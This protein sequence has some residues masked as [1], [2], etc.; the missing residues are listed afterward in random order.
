MAEGRP[1]L[2]DEGQQRVL[3]GCMGAKQL[4]L[5]Q[6][7]SPAEAAIGSADATVRVFQH[8]VFMLGR[9]PNR[10]KL[11]WQRRAAINQALTLYEEDQL[12]AAIEGMAADAL[13]DCTS[14]RI[15]DAMREI[16]WLL[17]KGARIER[18]AEAGDRL[19]L[20]AAAAARQPAQPEPARE[21]VDPAVTASAREAL[22]QMAAAR[23]GAPR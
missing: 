8:W 5:V 7:Q 18:W 20:E 10:C 11:D 1:P 13:D 9:S 4:K 22:R 16:E 3:E 2:G 12:M 15:R 14:D 19:R 21:P 23:R 6:M 17:A